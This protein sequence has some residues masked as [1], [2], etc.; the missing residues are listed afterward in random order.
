MLLYSSSCIHSI[1]IPT[2][3]LSV[4]GSSG[5]ISADMARHA[6]PC[7]LTSAHISTPFYCGS[8]RKVNNNLISCL[9]FCFKRIYERERSRFEFRGHAFSIPSAR[10][11]AYRA[12]HVCYNIIVTCF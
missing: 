4:S 8:H 7:V 10:N 3:A 9:F 6:R 2:T 5:I 12:V 11:C 1:Q